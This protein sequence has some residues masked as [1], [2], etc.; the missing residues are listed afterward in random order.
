[1]KPWKVVV[2]AL[3]VLACAGLPVA[4]HAGVPSG[5]VTLAAA[6]GSCPL[7]GAQPS[8]ASGIAAPAPFLV[9]AALALD[10]SPAQVCGP[11]SDPVCV[12][13]PLNSRCSLTV[14]LCQQITVCPNSAAIVPLC[15]CLSPP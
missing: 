3:A 6:A 7:L 5:P 15:E 8:A 9:P 10:A 12:G 11:C 4:L 1:M 13:K 2:A 14:R